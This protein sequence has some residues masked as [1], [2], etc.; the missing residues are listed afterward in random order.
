MENLVGF[1]KIGTRL[2]FRNEKYTQQNNE[3]KKKISRKKKL[4]RNN[5]GKCICFAYEDIIECKS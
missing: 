3:K 1:E 2:T 5:F 4:K